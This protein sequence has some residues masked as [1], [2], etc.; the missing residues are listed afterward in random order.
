MHIYVGK[1]IYMYYSIF[2]HK[3]IIIRPVMN[4]LKLE[5]KKL[6]QMEQYIIAK[7]KSKIY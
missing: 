5:K 3:N 1:N 7:N 6:I 2:Q 4:K